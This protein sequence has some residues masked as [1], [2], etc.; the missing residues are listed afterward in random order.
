LKQSGNELKTGQESTPAE[1]ARRE[2]KKK[3]M[4]RHIYDC[5][6]ALFMKKGYENTT[7]DEIAEAADVG[8]ATFFNHYPVKE[9]VLHEIASYTVNYARGIFDRE[10]AVDNRSARE[11][12]MRSLHEFGRIFDRNPRHYRSVVLDVMR[13]QTGSPEGMKVPADELIDALTGHLHAEQQRGEIDS[14]LDP[15][16]LAEMLTGIYNYTILGAIRSDHQ[17]S[18]ADRCEKAADIFISGC[19]PKKES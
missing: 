15:R 2:R 13:S 5:A 7:I 16:Q 9:D 11:K 3:A 19:R 17:G 12:T 18:I 8:R 14:D 1:P 6:V 4:K 10:F